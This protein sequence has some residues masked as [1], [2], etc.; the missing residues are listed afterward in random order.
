MSKKA[1]IIVNPVAG[2]MKIKNMLFDLISSIGSQD[3][4]STVFITKARGDATTAAERFTR[5]GYEL[6]VCCGG[7]GTLNEVISGL[8]KVDRKP[9]LLYYP[10]GSTNDFATTLGLPKKIDA[11][12][13]NIDSRQVM[14]LDIG[15]LNGDKHFS[16]IT[17]FGIF[18]KAS[19]SAPQNVK[20]TIGHFAYILEGIKELPNLG[21]AYHTKVTYDGGVIEG[22]FA[23]VA[24]TNS[25]SAGG[26]LRLPSEQVKLND[27]LFE[28]LLI[29][30]LTKAADTSK[31]IGMLLQ[32][33]Y[34]G[35]SIIMVQTTKVKIE[36]DEAP[37][38]CT[39]GEFAGE[40]SSADIECI[41]GAVRIVI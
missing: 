11:A 31:V 34:D 17:S 38:W 41:K 30:G 8:L 28:V 2:K 19:F 32:Q 15:T 16:Y 3:Y 37:Q 35:E 39:D 26:V 5:D 23:L 1:A 22:D 18:T 10:C 4:E 14:D 36:C 9:L 6:I 33:K 21:K 24:V 12:A 20:N 29:K 27:G 13:I 7:D 40:I 25:T